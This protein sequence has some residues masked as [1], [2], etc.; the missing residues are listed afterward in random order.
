MFRLDLLLPVDKEGRNCGYFLYPLVMAKTEESIKEQAKAIRHYI[1]LLISRFLTGKS[2]LATIKLLKA[3][4]LMWTVF[5]LTLIQI[6]N[7]PE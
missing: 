5:K 3:S 7:H 1:F 2:L 6:C 4:V